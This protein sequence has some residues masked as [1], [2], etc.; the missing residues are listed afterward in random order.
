MLPGFDECTAA[1]VERNNA[2]SASPLTVGARA[3]CKH[4]HRDASTCWW[5]SCSGSETAK[6]EAALVVLARILR[7]AVWLNLHALPH[8]KSVLEAEA[9]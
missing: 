1:F 5:G 9:G 3:L 8:G 7:G 2:G 6:N 4:A